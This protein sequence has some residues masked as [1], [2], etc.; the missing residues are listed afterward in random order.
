M[1]CTI[2]SMEVLWGLGWWHTPLRRICVYFK[3]VHEILLKT[4]VHFKLDFHFRG[5]G[6]RRRVNSSHKIPNLL[7]IKAKKDIYTHY[8]ILC[9]EFCF[10]DLK[11]TLS[12]LEI[13]FVCVCGCVCVTASGE[14]GNFLWDLTHWSWAL[15]L[16]STNVTVK[17]SF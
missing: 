2:P 6:T 15:S 5:L 14:E 17:H 4:R 7:R 1:F 16:F 3:Q 11:L 10:S 8:L 13:Q 9:G 12:L